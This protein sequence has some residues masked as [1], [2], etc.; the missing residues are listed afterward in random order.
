MLTL[1]QLSRSVRPAANIVLLLLSSIDERI[2]AWTQGP[3]GTEGPVSREG[4][5]DAPQNREWG[6]SAGYDFPA[7]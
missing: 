6:S 4:P 3:R 5:L 2:S 7:P 1:N